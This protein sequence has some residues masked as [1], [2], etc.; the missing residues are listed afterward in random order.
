MKEIADVAGWREELVSEYPSVERLRKRA[1]QKIPRFAFEYV[2]GACNQKINYR[3]NTDEIRDIELKAYYL[4]EFTQSSMKTEL[5]GESYDAPFGIAPVGLQGLTWPAAPKIL[6]KAALK[7]NI[8]YALSTVSTE[9]IET[10]GELT[11]GKAWF[12][13]YNPR[14]EKMTDDIMKRCEAVG[15]KNFM[16]LADVPTFGY[17]ADEIKNGLSLPPRMTLNNIISIFL[18]PEWAIKT[19]LYGQPSFKTMEKYMEGKKMNLKELGQYMNRTFDGRL[20]MDSVKRLRDK[21]KGNL[22]FKGIENLE[23]AQKVY[24]IGYDALL[25]SNHGGRQHDAGESTIATAEKIVKEFKGKIPILLDSGVRTGPDIARVLAS[26]VDFVFLGRTF[27]YSV[28][29]LGEKGGNHAIAMLKLQLQQVLEQCGCESPKE[30]AQRLVQ[31][32]K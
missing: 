6:A 28:G 31:K 12:Q 8:P 26:G 14:D 25:L 29:A 32:E 20:S 13:L 9:S 10:I 30:L 1:M 21:W 19:L 2:D 24:D 4:R 3:K 11:E 17:R 23:D 5:F 7:H 15:I 27:M 22:I 16:V 18:S